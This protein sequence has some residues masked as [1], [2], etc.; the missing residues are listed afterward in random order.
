[1]CNEVLLYMTTTNE[2]LLTI[3]LNYDNRCWYIVH[4]DVILFNGNYI[5]DC[6]E[7]HNSRLNV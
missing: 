7:Y 5:K 6:Y 3:T 2:W 1:M 4:K